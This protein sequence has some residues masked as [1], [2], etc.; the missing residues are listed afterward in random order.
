[1]AHAKRSHIHSFRL[2]KVESY[3]N[4]DFYQLSNKHLAN[5]IILISS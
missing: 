1:M 5:W 4:I 3:D 2:I